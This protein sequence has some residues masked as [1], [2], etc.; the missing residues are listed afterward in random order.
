[1][2]RGFTGHGRPF[3]ARV[4]AW[5]GEVTRLRPPRH[6]RRGPARRWGGDERTRRW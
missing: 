2:A 5:N 4:N 6:Y 3:V 1:M